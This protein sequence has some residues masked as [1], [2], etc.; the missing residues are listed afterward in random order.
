MD[1]APKSYRERQKEARAAARAIR[2]ARERERLRQ[3]LPIFEAQRMARKAVREL[4]RA[5]G[6]K[7]TD[8][9]VREINSAAV[10]IVPRFIEQARAKI[11]AMMPSL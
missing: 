4:I 3:L 11:E 2:K 7:V 9:S 5:Q 8:Y 10:V 1:E 6:K